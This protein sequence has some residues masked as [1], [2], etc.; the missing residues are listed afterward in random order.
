ML[1]FGVYLYVDC[2]IICII[3]VCVVVHVVV[4]VVACAVGFGLSLPL[5]LMMRL[6]G[7]SLP[8]FSLSLYDLIMFVFAGLPVVVGTCGVAVVVSYADVRVNYR[9]CV[10]VVMCFYSC[11]R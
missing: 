4:L 1:L 10:I 2:V 11:R 5:L 9:I 7:M 8:M 3:V 6:S